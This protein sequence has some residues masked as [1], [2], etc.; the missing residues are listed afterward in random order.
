MRDQ[1]IR[2]IDFLHMLLEAV[3]SMLFVVD[4]DLRV[5]HLN[6]AA[7]RMFGTGQET[8]FMHRGGEVLHCIHATEAPDGCGHAVI[9][10]DCMIR[11]SVIEAVKRKGVQRESTKLEHLTPAGV[12]DTHLQIT[13]SPIA[14]GGE[15]YALLAIEDI[16]ELMKA[17]EALRTSEARLRNMTSVLGEGVYVLDRNNCLTFMNPEAEKLLGWTEGELLGKAVHEVFHHQRADGTCLPAAEC[18]VLK[19]ITTGATYRSEENTFRRKDGQLFPAAVVATPLMEHGQITGS[20]TVFQDI[21][22]RKHAAEQLQ[23]LNQLLVRQATT[24]PL[25]GISNRLKFNDTLTAEIHRSRRYTLPLSLIMFDIDRF[26]R[27]NDTYGHHVGDCVLRELSRAV[28]QNVRIHDLFARW[29]G[30]EF[31]IMVTNSPL[32]NARLFAEKLRALIAEHRFSCNGP[33]TCSFGVAQFVCDETDDLFTRRVDDAL[34]RAKA[35]GGNRV[36]TA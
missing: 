3:P 5:L 9:C 13:A 26:K 33:V 25:T 1:L 24:D 11:N 7:S 6:S 20:V 22:E 14:Y 35:R 28:A 31:M 2:D 8:A 4:S 15:T 17:Q 10:R 29:G 23:Q 12:A 18:P 36:E 16:S 30:E 21:S 19:T 34:Y 32:E 27:I